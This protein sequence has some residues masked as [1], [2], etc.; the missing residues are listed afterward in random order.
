M[1]CFLHHS[2]T[3]LPPISAVSML[4][5]PQMNLRTP[6]VWCGSRDVTLAYLKNKYAHSH[7]CKCSQKHCPFQ[8]KKHFTSSA[9]FKHSVYNNCGNL[10]KSAVMWSLREHSTLQENTAPDNKDHSHL[11]Q[12][13]N[14]FKYIWHTYVYKYI[15]IYIYIYMYVCRFN[16][17]LINASHFNLWFVGGFLLCFALQYVHITLV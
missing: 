4:W 11:Y 16:S 1:T 5:A 6:Q 13:Y 3:R 12:S 8:T 14:L 17:H 15:C 9:R 2:A 10:T 7:S